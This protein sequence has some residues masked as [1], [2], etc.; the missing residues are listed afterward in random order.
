[1][2]NEQQ[3][4]E[5]LGCGTVIFIMFLMCLFMGLFSGDESGSSSSSRKTEWNVR[6]SSG[7]VRPSMTKSEYRKFR[8]EV[9]KRVERGY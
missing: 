4:E 8:S 1:M 5:A 9:L 2:T 3:E 7:Q 6:D